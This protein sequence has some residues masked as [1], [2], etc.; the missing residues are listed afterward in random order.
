MFTF[1]PGPFLVQFSGPFYLSTDT[2]GS[3]FKKIVSVIAQ[4]VSKSESYIKGDDS[5]FTSFY[6]DSSNLLPQTIEYDPLIRLP[7]HSRS[8]HFINLS[9]MRALQEVLGSKVDSFEAGLKML[10]NILLVFEEFASGDNKAQLKKYI[11]E[12]DCLL[13]TSISSNNY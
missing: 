2:A 9:Y 11:Q 13:Y 12:Y 10:H 3:N 6:K 1:L 4:A 8:E 5:T 7:D